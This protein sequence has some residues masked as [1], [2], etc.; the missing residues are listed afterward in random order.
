MSLRDWLADLV[1]GGKRRRLDR[2]LARLQ[3]TFAASTLE[4][5]ALDRAAAAYRDALRLAVRVEPAQAAVLF[6]SY[7]SRIPTDCHARSFRPGDRA[8]L[9]GLAR[10]DDP[11]VLTVVLEL[12]ARLGLG[13]PQR[14]A[15]ERLAAVLGRSG[16]ADRLVF[17]LLRCQQLQL[18]TAET[19]TSPL[20]D[21]VARAPLER[22][23]P[24]WSSFLATLPETLLPR[25]FEVHHFLGRGADAVLLADTPAR[26]QEALACCRQSPRIA[27]V[28]A[29]LELAR[30]NGD[31]AA[32][33]GLQ[34][35]T[36]DLLW[37]AGSYAEALEPYR[38][39]GR[40]DRVSECHEQ[41][42]QFF[43]ALASCPA[44]HP[45]RLAGLAGLCLPGVDALVARQEFPEAARRAQGLV[46]HLERAADEPAVTARR[47]EVKN[48]RA[49]VLAAGREHFSRLARQTDSAGQPAVY[50]TWSR[51]EE[52]AVELA[53]AAQLARDAG[54]RYRACRLFDQADLC[55][56]RAYRLFG[57]AGLFG[58]A[59]RVLQEDA[60]PEGLA[61]RA[62]NRADGG[63]HAGAAQ[64]F[65]QA[66][67]LEEAAQHYQQ[68]GEFATAA[69]CLQQHLGDEAIE[70]PELVA[71]L[72]KAGALEELVEL[73][74]KACDA[75]H[76]QGRHTRAVEVLRH[77]LDAD[78]P[79]LP[80]ELADKVR[81]ILPKGKP[82][83]LGEFE[84]RVP[85]W[86]AQ[87]RA[88]VDRRY[89]AIWGLDLGTTT[90][91]AAIYDTR[92]RQPVLC[93]WKGREQFASTLS[94]DEA[95]NELVGLAGEEMFARGVIDHISASKREMGTRKLYHL[96]DR[97]YRPEEVAARLIRHAR[98]LI[99]GF[100]TARVLER[101]GELARAE[102]PEVPDDWLHWAGQHH[103][104]R[105][106]RP[107]VVVTIPAYFLNNQ[108]HATRD[109]CQIAGVEVV[110]LLHEPTAACMAVGREKR[111]TGGVLVVDLGAGTLDLS[112]LDVAEGVYD[113]QQV[114]GDNHYGG[115]D[116]DS[117]ISQALADRLRRQQG[118]NVPDSG[119]PRR[120]L[121]VAAEY[122]KI[123]L[124]T[125]Q[126]SDFLLR[127][128]VD[129]Q[130]VQLELSR[131]ELEQI[132]AEPLRNLRQTC[133]KFK[134]FLKDRPQSLVL[135]GGPMLAPLVHLQVEE[136]FGLTRTGVNDPR[137]AAACGAAL[138]AAVLAGKA[139]DILLVDVTPLP[140][141][142][143]SFDQKDLQHF[144]I[145]I[146]R[147]TT[148]PVSKEQTF[149]TRDDNQ[150]A[151]DIEILQGQLDTESMIGQL[152]LDGIRPAKKGVPQIVVK[153]TIDASCVLEVTARD[154]DTGLANSLELRDS[155]L[156]T[157]AEKQGMAKRLKQQQE[158]EAQRQQL[159]GLLEDLTRQVA[160][161]TGRNSDALV[162]EWRSRLAAYRPSSTR[163]D[164][165]TEQTLFEMFNRGNESESE[166]LLV[167]TPLL[168]LAARAR[169]YL[170]R[171]EKP[172]A[173][174]LAPP[175][176]A[177]ALAEG[178]HLASEL[179]RHLSLLR[180]LRGKLAG[181]NALLVKL[182]TAETDPL[183]R[184]LACHEARDYARALEALAD[185]PGPLDHL[186]HIQVQ[187]NCLGQV[188]DAAGYRRVLFDNAERFQVVPFDPE[189]P[190]LFLARVQPALAR[191]QVHL[192]DG[193]SALGSGFL[194][195]DRLVA[196]NQRW[197]VAAVAGPRMPIGAD[198][199]EVQLGDGPRRVDHVFLSRSAQGDIALVRLAEPAPALPLRLG[200]ARLVRIGDPV[201]MVVPEA[202]PGQA[203]VSGVVNKFESFPD[204]DL[205]LFKV[206]ARVTV[207][208]SGGPLLNDLGEVVGILTIKDR[209]GEPVVVDTCFAQTAD[210]LEP[211]RATAGFNPRPC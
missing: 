50:D 169:Q 102:L 78:D 107:R 148:I 100:L 161:A 14:E 58:E 88:E 65:D 24:L 155:I 190:D 182:A 46:A 27:D 45:E 44:E 59:D 181:W 99:E 142:I 116:F 117:A 164:S 53:R 152:R 17:H 30:R 70:S 72:R 5:G 119:V 124:S 162:R 208:S 68:A 184:F 137:T 185:L 23:R 180:P 109:A 133:A 83:G 42:G 112:F 178:Q 177:A 156:L 207:R 7:D 6:R 106:F 56:Y 62:R 145:L 172:S 141:G 120:R 11:A 204:L 104:L 211:L 89:A 140:L 4:G 135:V 66:G 139:E 134:T 121:E 48:L 128:F 22:D 35:H 90:C 92:T 38:E 176:L 108:K 69:R 39:A 60:T 132:L 179:A 9:A 194:L 111:L 49:G 144:S 174:P 198:R 51:F 183:R 40:L 201:W 191:V 101:V 95:G 12:A 41:L 47:T 203:L 114:E 10:G 8:W 55:R 206:G 110:R 166:L 26:R 197:L 173:G 113:V 163:L 15:A 91:S 168:H 13:V 33:R 158:Q 98:D 61:A 85:A 127:S 193:R 150:P 64:L 36:G 118:I 171:T 1:A 77:L 71:C 54:G 2:V 157:P 79:P 202:A 63:D 43:E 103:D 125:Q 186:A 122:L 16:D 131:A 187:L 175:A 196:T 130:D 165:E 21:H 167:E 136:A 123:E 200:H 81:E 199:I 93:P 205:R 105:L 34:E 170:A 154:K 20:R 28:E 57:Q 32:L 115:K 126:H 74:R 192:A 87:A 138:Q 97:S 52:E 19:L 84:A 189:R 94:L 67:L 210:S 75:A 209:A 146:D 96:G 160:D 86:V 73:C 80:P 149:S 147:N 153:F 151:V 31:A 76:L 37:A 29:G 143:R 82:L 159:R 129:G 195:S 188:G 25:L 18:L 3:T